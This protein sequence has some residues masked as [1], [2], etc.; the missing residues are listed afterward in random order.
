M[1]A[2]AQIVRL[3]QRVDTLAARNIKSWPGK[4][5]LIKG[6]GESK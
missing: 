3:T 6:D 1:A 2:R 5:V 4:V